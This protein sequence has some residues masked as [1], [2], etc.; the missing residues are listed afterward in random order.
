MTLPLHSRCP[1]PVQLSSLGTEPGSVTHRHRI[2]LTEKQIFNPAYYYEAE[3]SGSTMKCHIISAGL[4]LNYLQTSLFISIYQTAVGIISPM[5]FANEA[6]HFQNKFWEN[7]D[8]TV[9]PVIT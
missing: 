7:H 1:K 3:T 4:W 5:Q 9:Q 2:L 8:L 6:S